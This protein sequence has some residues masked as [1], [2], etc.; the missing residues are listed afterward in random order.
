[1]NILIAND[2][3][4]QAEGIR[5]LAQALA[6]KGKEVT[7]LERLPE[8]C[9]ETFHLTRDVMLGKMAACVRT[10]TGACCTD[11]TKEGVRFTDRDGNE[12]FVPADAV[13]MAAGMRPRQELAESFRMTAPDFMPIGDCVTARNV[14]TATRMAFDAAVRI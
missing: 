10:Y 14:R 3:G 8:L 9:G 2:D 12:Q 7:V 4:I 13:V 5:A 11:I 6:E 1:M